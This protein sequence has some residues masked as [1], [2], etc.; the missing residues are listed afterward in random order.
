MK[1][2]LLKTS[3]L[4]VAIILTK[5]LLLYFVFP[6]SEIPLFILIVAI[7][8][9]ASN[10]VQYLLLRTTEK[11]MRKFNPAFLGL[12]MIKMFTYLILALIYIWFYRESAKDFLVSIF[13]IYVSFSALEI[14]EITRIVKQKK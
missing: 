14:V 7:F 1:S 8:F 13:V 10:F 2:F 3:I 5:Y 4:S 6:K 11:N 12:S 9:A